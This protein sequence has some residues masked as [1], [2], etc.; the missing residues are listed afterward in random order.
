MSG[1]ESSQERRCPDHEDQNPAPSSSHS[2]LSH[3]AEKDLPGIITHS[4]AS[5]CARTPTEG[6]LIQKTRSK[7]SQISQ[8]VRAS[9]LDGTSSTESDDKIVLR[10]EDGDP[11]N[12]FNWSKVYLSPYII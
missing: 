5:E 6:T 10:F 4:Y 3:E 7:L 1:V 12:P 8:D 2:T 9:P 11:E